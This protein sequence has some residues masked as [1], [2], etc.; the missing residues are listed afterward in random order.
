MAPSNV[1]LSR[2]A[3]KSSYPEEALAVF[4]M[5]LE[6]EQVELDRTAPKITPA[7]RETFHQQSGKL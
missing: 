3:P 1:F 7:N 5:L 4:K 6:K 2:Y